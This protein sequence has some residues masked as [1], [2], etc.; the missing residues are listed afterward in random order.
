M[1]AQIHIA[2]STWTGVSRQ[3]VNNS[4]TPTKSIAKA[5]TSRAAE[6]ATAGSG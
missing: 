1:A 6:Q 5:P 4:L 2:G 3:L